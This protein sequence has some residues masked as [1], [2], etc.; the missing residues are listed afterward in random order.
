MFKLSLG[1]D[2]LRYRLTSLTAHDIHS[3]FVFDL[4]NDVIVDQTP[5]YG[6][7][8]IE[9]LRA[10]H[11]FDQSVI[12]I[13]DFGTRS[14]RDAKIS[15]IARTSL[16]PKKYAQLLFRLVNHFKCENILEIGTS[17]GIT[18]LY[19][20]F[21]NANA[22]VITLEGSSALAG[23]ASKNFERLKRKN[24]EVIV[25]EFGETLPKALDKFG[26]VDFVY[27]D[28]NHRLDPTL[29]YFKQCLQHSHAE[30]V[31]VFDD[32]HWSREMQEAWLSI[33]NHES[34][35]CTIDLFQLG[36]VFFRTGMTKQHFTIKY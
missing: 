26:K 31:F 4:L 17:L 8:L 11:L 32:I 7:E 29:Q 13:K 14:D 28:G 19:L 6:F 5:F 12:R 20:S 22:R 9:S 18:S 23:L 2:Y 30:S 33:C 1:R 34:V 21:P 15:T 10:K 3:P 16:K 25:G 27:F 36:L 24:L 35:T